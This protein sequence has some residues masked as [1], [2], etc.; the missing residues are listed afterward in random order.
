MW[1]GTIALPLGDEALARKAALG[2]LQLSAAY[3]PARA[4]A[5]RVALLGGRLDEALKATEDLDP[6]APDVAVVRAASAYERVD[7]DGASRGL[8]ALSPDS[9]KLP[10][11][12][13]LAMAP[14]VLYGRVQLDATKLA[15]LANNEDA[16]W[17]NL[18][19]MDVALDAGDLAGADKIASGWG[20]AAESQPLQ[21][22]RLARLARYEGRL[23]A[24]DALS[25]AAM[26]AATVT[27]RV[28][29]ERA[30]TLV[31]RGRV[32][33]VGPLLARY[34]LPM[35]SG[36]ARHL[37]ERLHATASSGGVEAAKGKSR[38]D[39]SAR[40]RAPRSKRASW[41]RRRRSAR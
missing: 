17:S 8:D 28:L 3:E 16:P 1:L 19:A 25:Q 14:D 7:P 6:A 38:V 21:A 35:L 18:I 20:K 12:A 37:V 27:P 34:P 13:A 23:D 30:F 5:A 26:D 39:R 2:A 40:L 31:A 11:V 41:L 4:L 9:R 10:F 22:L 36:R 15:A 29:W 33:E 32:A 24:A